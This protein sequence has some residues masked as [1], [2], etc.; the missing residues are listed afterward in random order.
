MLT[1]RTRP[2]AA[3][4]L[5]IHRFTRTHR[6]L[7]WSHALTFLALAATGFGLHVHPLRRALAVVTTAAAPAPAPAPPV[8]VRVFAHTSLRLTDVAWTGR[9][10][11][12]VENTT[13][14]IAAAGPSGTPLRPFAK[15]PRQVEET[16]CVVALGGHGFAAGDLYCHAPDN[17]IY[18]LSANGKRVAVFATLPHAPRSDGALTF[19]TVGTFGYA[20]LVATGRSGGATARGGMVYAIDAAGRGRAIGRYHNPGGADEIA[21]APGHLGTA[22]GQLLLAVDAGTGGSLVA[23]DARGR[24]RTLLTLP[25]GP[26]PLVVLAP[27]QTPPAGAARA[28]L[29]VADTLSRDVYLAPAVALRPYAGAVL[30]GSE[31]RGLFWV[32]R[33]R[34]RGFVALPL[35]TTLTGAQ[36]RKY[37]LEGAVYIA[38]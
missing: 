34:G 38:R 24:T 35:A 25:D 32:L 26:N 11:L 31:L 15:L 16:R 9:Q 29:Y 19:D 5:W 28:G 2:G 1:E 12:Y 13:N 18:R 14:R 3:T 22:S 6:L 36:H 23:M 20:L 8:P 30:V 10:F 17:T 4:P 21:V 33:P 37:N 7:H 27:G